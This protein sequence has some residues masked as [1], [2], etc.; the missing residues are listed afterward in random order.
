V[1]DLE[2]A[3]HDHRDAARRDPAI[4]ITAAGSAIV[5]AA[6]VEIPGINGFFGCVPLARSA[7]RPP[8]VP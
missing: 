4:L 2:A 6:I 5:L 1:L 3:I 7:G 8:S